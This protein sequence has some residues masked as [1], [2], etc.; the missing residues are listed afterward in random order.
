M[1]TEALES[2]APL[3]GFRLDRPKGKTPEGE[4]STTDWLVPVLTCDGVLP[5]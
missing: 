2:C 4:F 3:G 1:A 5:G